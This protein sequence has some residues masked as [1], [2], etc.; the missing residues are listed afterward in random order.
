MEMT[1]AKPQGTT[2][3]VAGY[4][5]EDTATGVKIDVTGQLIILAFEY[6]LYQ[7]RVIPNHSD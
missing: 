4:A 7:G 6:F 5:L 1:A 3:S 2:A